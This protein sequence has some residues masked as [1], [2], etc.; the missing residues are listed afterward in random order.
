MLPLD[1]NWTR[2]SIKDMFEHQR[3]DGWMPRQISTISRQAPHDMRYYC[4]GGAFLL[5]L[6]HEYMTFTR[7]TDLL[8]ERVYW[9]DSDKESTV[10]EHIISCAGFY[11]DKGNIGEHGLCKVWYGDWWDVM[12]KIGTEGRGES[13]TVT[14]QTVLNLENL[15]KM[16]FLIYSAWGGL[17]SLNFKQVPR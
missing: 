4:D 6:I 9:L 5:E 10:L 14:A 13:V 15:A 12:D 7:D 16:Q 17:E 1:P 8:F 11:L 2:Q 3:T